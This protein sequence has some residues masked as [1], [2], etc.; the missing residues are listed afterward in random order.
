M[1]KIKYIDWVRTQDCCNCLETAPS[2]AHH[3]SGEFHLSGVGRKS[4]DWAAMPLCHRCHRAFHD[5]DKRLWE[6]REARYN[7]QRF[8][9]LSTL[10]KAIEG[11]VVVAQDVSGP[12]W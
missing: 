4:P 3:L 1:G 6:N 10:I 2:Q 12:I 9:L 5:A 8:W 7:D 11:G